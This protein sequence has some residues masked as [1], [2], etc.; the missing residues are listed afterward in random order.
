MIIP[1]GTEISNPDTHL[2]TKINPISLSTKAMRLVDQD[3]D[4]EEV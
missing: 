1:A 3:Q 4:I 2:G